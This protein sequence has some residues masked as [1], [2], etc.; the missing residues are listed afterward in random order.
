MQEDGKSKDL[1]IP[2]T[3]TVPETKAHDSAQETKSQEPTTPE[4]KAQEREAELEQDQ[5][6]TQQD[7]P[8]TSTSAATSSPAPA[9]S[10]PTSTSSASESQTAILHWSR[11]IVQNL[12]PLSSPLY[13]PRNPGLLLSDTVIKPWPL[14]FCPLQMVWLFDEV[15]CTERGEAGGPSYM[16]TMPAL[17][18]WMVDVNGNEE[19]VPRSFMLADILAPLN[20]YCSSLWAQKMF[21]LRRSAVTGAALNLEEE[22][23]SLAEYRDVSVGVAIAACGVRCCSCCWD[24]DNSCGLSCVFSAWPLQVTICEK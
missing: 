3:P 7:P 5:E 23:K 21:A 14:Y 11:F 2:A 22:A 6:M 24:A 10:S 1:A 17:P 4:E 19:C 15:A 8:S 9:S 12:V 13:D 16:K 18:Y 20:G